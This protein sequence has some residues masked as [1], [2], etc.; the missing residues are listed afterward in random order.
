MNKSLF[1]LLIF[2]FLTGILSALSQRSNSYK[3][4][5]EIMGEFSNLY[6]GVQ[7]KDFV[8]FTTSPTLRD[9]NNGEVAIVSTTNNTV[10]SICIKANNKLYYFQPFFTQP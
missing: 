9:L 10:V 7:S 3:T 4:E 2:F 6:S 1:G 8:I 5:T